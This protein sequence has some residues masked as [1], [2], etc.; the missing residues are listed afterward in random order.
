MIFGNFVFLFGLLCVL[1]HFLFTYRRS[2]T[3][4]GVSRAGIVI[5]MLTFGSM[6]GFTVLGR[7]ALLIERV[8]ILE[9]YSG[10]DYSLLAAPTAGAPEGEF[11]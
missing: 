2:R 6:F 3:L 4:S 9:L 1:G 7:I 10:S 5:L 11:V 8:E